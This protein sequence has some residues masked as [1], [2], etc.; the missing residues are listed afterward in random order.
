MKTKKMRR[1]IGI[2][3]IL[4]IVG[5][6]SPKENSKVMQV[7]HI[8]DASTIKT[9]QQVEEIERKTIEIIENRSNETINQ[10]VMAVIRKNKYGHSSTGVEKLVWDAYVGSL[11]LNWIV[12]IKANQWWDDI[13]KEL[14]WEFKEPISGDDIDFIHLVAVI[15]VFYTQSDIDSDYEKYYDALL[16]WGGDLL[17]MAYSG[18]PSFHLGTERSSYFSREDYLADIDGVNIAKLMK[19]ENLLLS[20]ALHEYYSTNLVNDRSLL[21]KAFYGGDDLAYQ[22]F[23]EFILLEGD[24]T[25][26]FTKF[27][28]TFKSIQEGLI[29]YIV[30]DKE[31]LT[32]DELMAFIEVFITSFH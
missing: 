19:D 32:D 3:L 10:S 6:I 31:H 18:E 28:A 9:I 22:F 8:L 4:L 16:S 21:F 17:T 13:F 7:M 11:P 2:L 23:R 27:L 30:T 25:E 29:Q 24:G 1:L 20:E 26:A 5:C 12:Y 15:D 14:T